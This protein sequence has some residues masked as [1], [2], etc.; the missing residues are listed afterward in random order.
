M[1]DACLVNAHEN[2]FEPMVSGSRS[3]HGHEH[4]IWRFLSAELGYSKQIP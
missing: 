1:Y 2:V 4:M 3:K